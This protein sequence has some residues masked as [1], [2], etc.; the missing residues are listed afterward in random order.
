MRKNPTHFDRR[1]ALF[2]AFALVAGAAASTP[3][4]NLPAGPTVAVP[5]LL[6]LEGHPEAEK[7]FRGFDGLTASPHR[8][9]KLSSGATS[10]HHTYK[11]SDP[12]RGSMDFSYDAVLPAAAEGTYVYL[13]KI[14]A[15]SAIDDCSMD[16]LLR[17]EGAEQASALAPT[18]AP[19]KVIIA[20][21]QWHCPG[22][23]EQAT[24]AQ[25][26]FRRVLAQGISEGGNFVRVRTEKVEFLKLFDRLKVKALYTPPQDNKAHRRKLAISCAAKGAGPT[27]GRRR[28][29]GTIEYCKDIAGWAWNYADSKITKPSIPIFGA[30]SNYACTDCYFKSNYGASTHLFRICRAA[31]D[32]TDTAACTTS[33]AAPSRSQAWTSCWYVVRSLLAP[34]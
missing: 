34:P 16:L 3:D 26:V 22:E 1:F 11:A 23:G 4:A 17:T 14:T 15:I 32:R 9:R 12:A 10:L 8:S 27:G 25:P 21:G 31:C 18:F 24:S 2:V 33:S 5:P 13:D 30:E 6:P 7:P 20:G 29:G 28:G 19:G